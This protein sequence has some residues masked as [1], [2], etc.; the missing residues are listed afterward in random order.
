LVG[1]D[2]QIVSEQAHHLTLSADCEAQPLRVLNFRPHEAGTWQLQLEWR[3][4]ELETQRNHYD[5]S[6][7]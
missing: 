2:S 6:V 7:T 3:C 5:L 1:P 4:G